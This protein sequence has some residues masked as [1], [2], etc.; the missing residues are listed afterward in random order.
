MKY[1]KMQQSKFGLPVTATGSTQKVVKMH[2]GDIT[3]HAYSTL[4]YPY[5]TVPIE[6]RQI[7]LQCSLFVDLKIRNVLM[8]K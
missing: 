7:K 6:T 4:H 1:R 2:V 3:N 8:L 5:N